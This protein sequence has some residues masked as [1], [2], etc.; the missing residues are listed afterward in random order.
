[1]RP[2]KTLILTGWT[3][4]YYLAAA[5]AAWR[6]LQNR[7]VREVEVAGVSM[8]ALARVLAERGPHF[9][10]VVVLGVGLKRHHEDLVKSLTAL[11]KDSRSN[12]PRSRTSYCGG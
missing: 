4:P 12:F 6:G 10:R 8:D 9:A 2:D 11:R 1:M 7:Q 5:A 3:K